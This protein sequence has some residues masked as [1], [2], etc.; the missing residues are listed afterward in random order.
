MED[1]SK[2]RLGNS[3]ARMS[4]ADAE[5]DARA[6]AVF[7]AKWW[8]RTNLEQARW[9]S[10]PIDRA[11]IQAERFIPS[12]RAFLEKHNEQVDDEFREAITL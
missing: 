3:F 4:K 6:L 5:T 10:A 8:G 2:A 11:A 12:G 7:H 9:L 1:L